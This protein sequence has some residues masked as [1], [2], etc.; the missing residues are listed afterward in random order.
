MTGQALR[1]CDHG[2]ALRV[3]RGEPY[4]AAATAATKWT[5]ESAAN[6]IR[7]QAPKEGAPAT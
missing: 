5:P 4:T 2:A 1:P 3:A 6:A 7:G